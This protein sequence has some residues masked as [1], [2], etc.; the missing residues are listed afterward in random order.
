M[1]P[2][3]RVNASPTAAEMAYLLAAGEAIDGLP[4][5]Y[6]PRLTR[7]I[8][9]ALLEARPR[10]HGVSVLASIPLATKHR[11]IGMFAES[12]EFLSREFFHGRSVF[13]PP[14]KA[15]ASFDGLTR[16]DADAFSAIIAARPCI[17]VPVKE[18][19]AQ[20]FR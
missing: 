12:T 8:A 7:E 11:L 2:D 5:V 1:W 20:A 10:R 6:A 18:R 3:T 16:E 13:E 15:D 19:L 17:P 4:R 14:R 9:T